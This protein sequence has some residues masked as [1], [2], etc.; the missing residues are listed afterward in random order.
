MIISPPFLPIRAAGQSEESW[1]DAAMPP[2]ASRLPDT[3]AA[4]GSFP[5]SHNLCWH[6]GIHIQAPTDD[7]GN[8]PVR[9]IAD[10]VVLFVCAPATASLDV[11]HP[12][13]YNP[14]QRSG[15]ESTP[16]WT[17]NGCVILE[18]VTGIG[19]TGEAETQVTFY[20]A[21]MHLSELGHRTATGQ[22]RGPT[23]AVGDQISRKAVVGH[24][25][26]IYGHGGQIHFEICL[27]ADN[28]G[29]LVGRPPNWVEPAS[30][31]RTL[32]TPS[33]DGRIDAIFGSIYFYLPA[34][35]PTRAGAV[36][37]VDHVRTSPAGGAAT[38]G[39]PVWVR[40][41]Y[42][43]G[44]CRIETFD[45]RGASLALPLLSA[46]AE[47]DLFAE[48]TSRHAALSPVQRAA[49][50]PSAWYELLRFGR[51][52]GRGASAA[53]KDPL[54]SQAAH[55]RRIAGPAG[56]ALWADINAVGTYKFSDADFPA[57]MGWNWIDDDSN[58]SDQRCDSIRLKNLI[59]DSNPSSPGGLDSDALARR[60]G[61]ND[62]QTR[63]RRLWCRFPSEWNR[64]TTATRYAFVQNLPSFQQVPEAWSRFEAHL[65]S[66]SFDQL[67]ASYLGADWRVNP[68]ELLGVLRKCCWRSQHE[69]AR[70]FPR[71]LFYTT[72]GTRTAITTPAAVYSLAHATASTR[73]QHHWRS[74][75]QAMRKYCIE[76]PKRQ[77]HFLAQVMLETAQWRNLPPNRL[78]MH[79]WGFGAYSAANPMTQYYTS[80]Y[81]RGVMQLTW[82]GNYR[83]YGA[84]RGDGLPDHVGAYAE[85]STPAHPRTTH[86]S[87]H[88]TGNPADGA[89]QVPWSPRYDPDVIATDPFNA[90]DS[91]AFYWVSKHHGGSIN[92]NRV[93]DHVFD[94]ASVGRV[95]VLVNGGGNG[96][97]ERQA[98]AAFMYRYLSDSVATDEVVELQPPAPKAR[99]RANLLEPT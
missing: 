10:G 91:G 56:T 67:P 62:V 64:A 81:G 92:I 59:A 74:M 60:L 82:V 35:T 54:P 42:R 97:Y 63:L 43:E 25:G 72:S 83:D 18:H 94:P 29:R 40:M 19:T 20:S 87:V 12:Q 89:V 31:D 98:Y 75:N 45:E 77:A 50:S 99:I 34:S 88:W 1:L 9:A 58:P 95:S 24:P 49:S 70:T 33:A 6:N 68:R 86:T 14:F 3:H 84:F 5:L 53:D 96:Y 76:T 28:L 13:N 30:P 51:N 93:C 41:S 27:D 11:K 37:P 57:V 26:R 8:L 52:I 39:T 23:L 69:L 66:I 78:L 46:D 73:I 90:C 80:F 55:W 4:E 21:Y 22:T 71:H 17:D 44:G 65:K 2:T 15:A 61:D 85:R 48:A 79:E 47:Y 7:G 38:L 36:Q 32:P 16:A